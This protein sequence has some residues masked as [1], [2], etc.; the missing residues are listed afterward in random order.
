MDYETED[1]LEYAAMT[2]T[3]SARKKKMKDFSGYF[4][5]TFTPGQVEH[6]R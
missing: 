1:R 5:N 2:P 3:K 6:L 4:M